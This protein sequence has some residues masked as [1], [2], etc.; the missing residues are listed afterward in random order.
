MERRLGTQCRQGRGGGFEW[1]SLWALFS[2][3]DWMA[4]GEKSALT[5]EG[6]LVHPPLVCYEAWKTRG[7]EIHMF[8]KA[9]KPSDVI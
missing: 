6:R 9:C 8:K 1:P 2:A 5:V 4:E 3:S 7:P